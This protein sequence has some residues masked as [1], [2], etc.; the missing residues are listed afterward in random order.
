MS[1]LKSEEDRKTDTFTNELRNRR[2]RAVLFFVTIR[3]HSWIK[4]LDLSFGIRN[5]F[6]F[7]HSD[8]G[9][10]AEGLATDHRRRHIMRPPGRDG[11]WRD[12]RLHAEPCGTCCRRV[13]RLLRR[14]KDLLNILLMFG[15][16]PGVKKIAD[17]VNLENVLQWQRDL[18]P[19]H[20]PNRKIKN[21]VFQHNL[22]G[23]SNFSAASNTVIP[24]I[25]LFNSH[26]APIVSTTV[27]SDS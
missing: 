17:R 11:I 2:I 1:K 24:C 14:I 4:N 25:R 23:Q 22:C 27:T 18:W 9:F 3:V 12:R 10:P 7:R 8:F 15:A 20:L 26:P 5:C 19:H 16:A 6:G 21:G 13:T